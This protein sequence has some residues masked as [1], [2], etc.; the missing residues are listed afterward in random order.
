MAAKEQEGRRRGGGRVSFYFGGKREEEYF[1]YKAEDDLY[2]PEYEWGKG[3]EDGEDA[4]KE[5]KIKTDRAVFTM[6]CV[7]FVLDKIKPLGFLHLDVD[8]WYT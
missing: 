6:T 1:P 2:S 8:E 3:R 4:D 5:K 7:D